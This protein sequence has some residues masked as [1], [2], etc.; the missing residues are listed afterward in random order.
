MTVNRTPF[1][2]NTMAYN[3]NN[4]IYIAMYTNN[5]AS[6]TCNVP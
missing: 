1:M 5:V 4:I 6:N 3:I 2:S